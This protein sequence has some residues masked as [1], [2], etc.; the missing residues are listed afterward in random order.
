MPPDG[1]VEHAKVPHGAVEDGRA[2]VCAQALQGTH[3]VEE[4]AAAVRMALLKL[5][6]ELAP[7]L[8]QG[9][10]L[11]LHGERGRVPRADAQ[12]RQL[13]LL[14][15]LSDD[16][17]Q[18]VEDGHVY[19]RRHAGDQKVPGASPVHQ[20][21]E[22]RQHG[23]LSGSRVGAQDL[24][25]FS[26]LAT[27]SWHAATQKPTKQAAAHD[28][29]SHLHDEVVPASVDHHEGLPAE[30]TTWGFGHLRAEHSALSLRGKVSAHGTCL[31]KVEH[32][33]GH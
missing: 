21:Q 19:E 14:Y 32:L 16:R 29:L 6:H 22:L 12:V 9:G 25:I 11:D 26:V 8:V 18:D 33:R 5:L 30:P 27:A 2:V 3:L 17:Q 15:Q 28:D 4:G 7:P 23:R 13:V 20:L 1:R 24:Q 10:R 31:R